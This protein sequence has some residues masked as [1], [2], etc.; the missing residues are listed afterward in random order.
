MKKSFSF[1]I[2]FMII[3]TAFF[4]SLLAYL[5]YKTTDIIAYNQETDL[6]KTLLYV[7]NIEISSNDP[8]EIEEVFNKYVEKDELDGQTIYIVK[9]KGDVAGYAFPIAGTALWGTVEGYAAISNDYTTL[10]GVDFVSHSETPGLGGRI[11]EDW[12]KE[13]FRGLDLTKAKDG[14]Y[15]IYRPQPNGNLD[16]I[17]GAT[18]TSKSVSNFI[19]EDIYKFIELRK[20]EN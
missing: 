1:P 8:K 19:N 11:S 9:E 2:I 16:A 14:Q 20:G 4:T 17:A 6:R 18:Q 13:Q 3:I 15:I 12:F 7:F 10:L 5:N